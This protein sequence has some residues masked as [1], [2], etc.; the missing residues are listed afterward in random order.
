MFASAFNFDGDLSQW[1]VSKVTD[2]SFMFS[3]AS[4]FNGDLSKWDVSKVIDMSSMFY[5]ASNFN[6]DLR[7][8]DVSKVQ[9]KVDMFHG[10]SCSLC[11][12]VPHG[13]Q[14]VC[15]SSCHRDL[16]HTAPLVLV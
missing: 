3:L 11:D 10:D 4:K 5:D 13:L 14:G 16:A 15:Q 7:K 1:D 2:M 9:T 6:G 8:W 12:R